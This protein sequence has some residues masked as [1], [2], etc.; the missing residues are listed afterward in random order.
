MPLDRR[1]SFLTPEERDMLCLI[2]D[3][4]TPYWPGDKLTPNEQAAWDTCSK[5]A[6]MVRRLVEQL[7]K[8]Q[9]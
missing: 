6:D 7:K 8:S 2:L 1:F 4:Q 9:P 3:G 5:M